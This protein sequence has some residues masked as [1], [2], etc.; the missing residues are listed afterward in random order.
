MENPPPDLG[1][2]GLQ[3]HIGQNSVLSYDS[4]ALSCGGRQSIFMGNSQRKGAKKN[5]PS[6]F[7]RFVG[8]MCK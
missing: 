3:G 8:A 2:I 5:R 4:T 1:K 7:T 6:L